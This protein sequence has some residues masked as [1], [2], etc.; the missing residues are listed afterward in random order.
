M[1]HVQQQWELRHSPLVPA[2]LA[3]IVLVQSIPKVATGHQ[4]TGQDDLRL[5]DVG[6]H[7]LH[8]LHVQ[9]SIAFVW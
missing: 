6:T 7:E 4:L 3:V 2:K 8:N 1:V 5:C 9:A